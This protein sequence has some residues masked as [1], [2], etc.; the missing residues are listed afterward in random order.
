LFVL[1]NGRVCRYSEYT[2]AAIDPNSLPNDVD[3]LQ[4][5]DRCGSLRA[6]AARE[7]GEEQVPQPAARL[8]EAQ[9]NR[10][11]EQLSKEQLTLFEALWKTNGPEAKKEGDSEPDDADQKQDSAEEPPAAKKRSGR[12][13]LARNVIRERIVHD[14][15]EAEKHC[16]CCGKDL[17]LFDEESASAMSTFR[18]R[19]R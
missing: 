1:G 11:S 12:Q 5:E 6:A 13:P 16:G 9:R 2:T 10:K 8:L 18:H 3:I 15:P 4:K 19:S 7:F 14:L 17:R